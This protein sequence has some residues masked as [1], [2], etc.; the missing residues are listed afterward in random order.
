M[1]L[2][3]ERKIRTSNSTIGE[4]HVNSK[5]F[6]YTLEP[7]DR[8]LTSAMTLDQIKKIKVP[9][10]TAIPIGRYQVSKYFSPKHNAWV[11]ILLG[12][13]GFDYVEI[14]VGNYPKDTDACLLLGES[15]AVDMVG[16]SK[17]IVTKF[18][19]LFFEALHAGEQVWITYQ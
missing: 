17:E 15:K 9:S 1:E 10:K 2:L 4:F 6:S 11:P 19:G 16:T 13:K 3:V 14:H 7:T 12:V 18:Y 5:F 8:G